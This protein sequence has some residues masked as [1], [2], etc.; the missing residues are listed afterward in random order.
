MFWALITSISL[1]LAAGVPPSKPATPAD[2]APKSS[3]QQV[4]PYE[5][6]SSGSSYDSQ[7]EQQLLDLANAD[8]AHASLPALKMDDGL[9]QAARNHA[10]Q[11]ASQN[12]LSHQFS[13]EPPLAQRVA[14]NSAL[15]LDREGEN[16]AMAGTANQAHAALMSSP[17]HRDNLLSRNFNVAGFGVFRSGNRLYVAQDF[18]SSLPSYS[19]QQAQELVSASLEQ[20]RAQ[21]R[22]PRLQQ[23]DSR[24]AQSSACAM[25]QADSLNAAAPPAGAYMLRYTSM[26]PETLP[27]NISKVIAQR[28]LHTY[29]AGTCYAQTQKYPNG[30]YWVVLVFY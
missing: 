25:A 27:S 26:Q 1:H 28:G 2:T 7:A 13:G 17:P 14:A 15:H 23:V 18:G 8:R 3:W 11:M 16:V 29:S 19:L 5:T 4:S 6:P 12:Q 30:A 24:S 10:A 9:V 22:M 20:L 21:A